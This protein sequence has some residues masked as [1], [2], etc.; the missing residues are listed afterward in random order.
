MDSSRDILGRMTTSDDVH[1]SMG[2]GGDDT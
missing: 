2:F 1:M